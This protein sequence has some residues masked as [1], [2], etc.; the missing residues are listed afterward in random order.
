MIVLSWWADSRIKYFFKDHP[1]VDHLAQSSMCMW[2]PSPADYDQIEIVRLKSVD[3]I[4]TLIA[5]RPKTCTMISTE[6]SAFRTLKSGKRTNFFK[7][8]WEK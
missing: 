3:E 4:P 6:H 1:I 7:I 5:N 8:I 2:W